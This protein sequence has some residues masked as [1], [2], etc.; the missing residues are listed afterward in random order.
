MRNAEAADQD[1]G[2][3]ATGYNV[4]PSP[5]R[6]SKPEKFWQAA[7]INGAADVEQA[8]Q[9]MSGQFFDSIIGKT[10]RDEGIVV[11]PHRPVVIGNRIVAN[12]RRSQRAHSPTSK[13][14]LA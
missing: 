12:F 8:E 7:Q 1:C 10:F 5:L 3:H 6:R 13:E 4:G 2:E 11:R 14:V 9:N